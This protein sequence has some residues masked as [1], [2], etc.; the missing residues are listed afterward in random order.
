MRLFPATGS[1]GVRDRGG[2]GR[3]GVNELH[4]SICIVS[5]QTPTQSML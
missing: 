2:G 4:G 3:V 1:I 5:H